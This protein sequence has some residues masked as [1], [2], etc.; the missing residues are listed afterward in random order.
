MDLHKPFSWRRWLHTVTVLMVLCIFSLSGVQAAISTPDTPPSIESIP[1]DFFDPYSV[2]WA[3][4]RNMTSNQFS[5]Y[6]DEM[7]QKG[8]MVMD[9]EVDE[10]NGTQRVGAVWKKNTDGRGWA[11][12]RNL[13]DSEFHD[14]WVE[15]GNLGY[16]L[17][18][19]ESYALAGNQ[20]YAGV[21]IFNTEDLD[22]IS[23]RN[24]TSEEFAINFD[25]Y[26]NAGYLMIDIDAYP[27]TS[28]FRYAAVW[29]KNTENLAWA[30]WRDLTSEEFAAKFD[31][32]Q[33]EY[34]MIDVESYQINGNQYYAG[35]WVENVDGRGWYEY[36]DMTS[37]GFGDKWLQLRDAGYRLINYEVY[38]TDDGWRYA[39]IW[40]QNSTR[41]VWRLKD[42]VDALLEGH[43]GD[44][45]IPGM[46]V[47]IAQNGQ[48]LYLRGFGYADI[49]DEVI[50]HSR[51]V[52]RLASVSKA[53]AGVLSLEL[54]EGGMVNLDNTTASYVPAMPNLHT[55]DVEQTISNR[56][57]I[58][59]Y[60]DYPSISGQFDTA[61]AA[62]AEI[63]DL[64]LVYTPGSQTYYS[65]HAYT[66]LGA[67]LE[68]AVG[69]PIATIVDEHLHDP[70][71][72][73]SLQVEILNQPNAKRATLYDSNN[74]EVDPDN[75][76]WKVLG[77]GLESSAYDL[78][79]FGIMLMN[80][81]I[82]SED[83]LNTL[84]TP[85]DNTSGYALGWSTGTEEGFQ[86]VAKDGAQN[87][88]RSYMRM[89]PELGIVIVVLT[90]RK[91][92]GHSP[93]ELG[94]EIGKLM[95]GVEGSGLTAGEFSYGAVPLQEQE[96]PEEEATDPALVV[97]PIINPVSTPSPEDLQEP[98]EAW[99]NEVN[100]YLPVVKR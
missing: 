39:G 81:T 52:F 36:R 22:W 57:G 12:H 64:P 92:G 35:I 61:E 8:Y 95:L 78:A 21:W 69:D 30:E 47:A 59:H 93:V 86:V 96:E 13:T 53:V 67:A 31:E 88:S 68:G 87:G 40:R 3:S 58:G 82:L 76:S 84:W 66:F 29:V 50:A 55:H 48:F 15:L 9:I 18:D 16:R 37:K 65:T 54:S 23:Y 90:N 97:W 17:I 71:N 10:I 63:W 79:R 60:P 26:S 7:S 24:V 27:L 33:D 75:L 34:R 83:S 1:A 32:Y 20:L 14:K 100:I 25:R 4:V 11:E 94:R 41:P 80:G 6:F 98:P 70:F 73:N 91:S 46:S 19:Q 74:D 49:N 38:P 51:T 2:G 43:F 62:A 85:P 99:I 42:D 45:D 89:Y 72:L 56:S 44:Y 5:T 28:G 77:G